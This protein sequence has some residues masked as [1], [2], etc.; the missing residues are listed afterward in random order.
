VFRGSRRRIRRIRARRNWSIEL[1]IF[2]VWMIFVL[3]VVVPWI[4]SHPR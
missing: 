2:I 4:A 3:T 1:A